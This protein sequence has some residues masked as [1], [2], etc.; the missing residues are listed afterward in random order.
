MSDDRRAPT[1][2]N[3][4]I[5]KKDTYG[6]ACSYTHTHVRTHPHARTPW[7]N[8]NVA[9]D[10]SLCPVQP[11]TNA[12][13]GAESFAK[14]SHLK[15][16]WAAEKRRGQRVK[17]AIKEL[18]LGIDHTPLKGTLSPTETAPLFWVPEGQRA[19][20]WG[21]RV[22]LLDVKH[23]HVKAALF[24]HGEELLKDGCG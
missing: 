7:I 24:S 2:T 23:F 16:I 17:P 18:K 3:T 10:K 5:Q 1:F 19:T 15:T 20:G 9:C 21:G 22:C 14:W 12:I 6:F 4:H 11:N 13:R 8:T